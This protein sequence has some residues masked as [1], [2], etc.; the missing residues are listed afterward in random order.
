MVSQALVK[1]ISF[2]RSEA[3]G[4]VLTERLPYHDKVSDRGVLYKIKILPI[5]ALESDRWAKV[6]SNIKF[7]PV[8]NSQTY[9]NWILR[10]RIVHNNLD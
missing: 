6:I 2:E 7:L 3:E 5:H 10:V 9:D 1:Q 8:C 4:V